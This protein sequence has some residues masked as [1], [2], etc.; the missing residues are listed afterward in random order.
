MSVASAS[1]LRPGLSEAAAQGR[2][3]QLDQIYQELPATTCQRRGDC[4]GLLPPLHA[5]ELAAWLYR[6]LEVPYRERAAQARKLLTHF[7]SN[8]AQRL[9]CPW[10]LED[11]CSVYDRRFLGCR[12]YGLWSAEAYAQR[13]ALA[14]AGQEAVAQAWKGLGVE[15]PSEVLAP[16]PPYCGSV[17]PAE[18]PAP[19]DAALEALEERVEELG[20]DLPGGLERLHDFGGDLAYMVAALALGQ[21]QALSLKVAVTKALLGGGE[22]EANELL[23]KAGTAAQRWAQSL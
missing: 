10:A 13:A 1:G 6:F 3:T 9:A 7:L 17:R 21:Q 19:D 16:A 15:L 14:A 8:A 22:A 11:A 2:F 5:V 12:S 20:R 23:A 18:G 4:C